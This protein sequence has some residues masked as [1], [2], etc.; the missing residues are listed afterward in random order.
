MSETTEMDQYTRERLKYGIRLRESSQLIKCRAIVEFE[1]GANW[2]WVHADIPPDK[3]NSE[4]YVEE[5]WIS[6]ESVFAHDGE[7]NGEVHSLIHPDWLVAFNNAK[8]TRFEISH[9]KNLHPSNKLIV[10]Y[11]YP[12]SRSL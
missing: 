3:I 12:N 1:D 11:S 9:G 6:S 5:V 8:I 7:F 10:R 2:Q 4:G